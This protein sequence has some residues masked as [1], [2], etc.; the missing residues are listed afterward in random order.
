MRGWKPVERAIKSGV[1]VSLAK[2]DTG[3]FIQV[4][5]STFVLFDAGDLGQLAD[6]FVA[7]LEPQLT[8]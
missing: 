6:D 4:R 2:S 3:L 1:E 8:Q 5:Y 7:K